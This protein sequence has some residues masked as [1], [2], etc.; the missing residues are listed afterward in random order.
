MLFSLLAPFVCLC[1]YYSKSGFI[2]QPN[3]LAS[4]VSPIA[5]ATMFTNNCGL[6]AT[7]IDQAMNKIVPRKNARML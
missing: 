5:S 7:R 1:V 6:F 3:A 4:P 2:G